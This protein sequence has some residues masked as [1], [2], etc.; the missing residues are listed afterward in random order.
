[1]RL[2]SALARVSVS[3][4][5]FAGFRSNTPMVTKS[6]GSAAA[7][8]GDARI[9]VTNANPAIQPRPV[10]ATGF[11][12]TAGVPAVNSEARKLIEKGHSVC[13][14]VEA[15]AEVDRQRAAVLF[16]ACSLERMSTT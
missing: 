16:A 9:P 2:A 12:S 3:G 1:M 11:P 5:T 8:R 15:V 7:G 4:A 13:G 14:Q 10:P 6:V